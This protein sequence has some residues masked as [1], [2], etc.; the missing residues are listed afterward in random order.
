M[1]SLSSLAFLRLSLYQTTV[2]VLCYYFFCLCISFWI[3]FHIFNSFFLSSDVCVNLSRDSFAKFF[4]KISSNFCFNRIPIFVAK[5]KRKLQL[6]K[7]KGYYSLPSFLHLQKV[8]SKPPVFRPSKKKK[9]KCNQ[10]KFNNKSC[11]DTIL[12]SN[13]Q[14]LKTSRT[15]GTPS[16]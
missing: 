13:F 10:Q 3:I 12:S 4:R 11:P 1:L 8:F 2:H 16:Q 7:K 9:K 15:V 14:S 5:E 6:A